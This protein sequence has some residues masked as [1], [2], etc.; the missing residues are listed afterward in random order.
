LN[1]IPFFSVL[2]PTK[3]RSHIVG[4]AIQSILNQS[5]RDFEIILVDNDDSDATERSVNGFSDTRLKYFRTGSLNMCDNWEFA[6]EQA[7]GKFVTVLE[8]KQAYYPHALDKIHQAIMEKSAEVV[9]WGWDAYY[10]NLKMAC[11]VSQKKGM[12]MFT[13]DCI[14]NLYVTRPHA[15]WELL[16][17]VLNS[18][19]SHDL[20]KKIKAL[21]A[22]GK[23]FSEMS[24]D[25]CAAFYTLAH[26]EQ[27][28]LIRER[29]GLGGYFHLSN[30]KKI[31]DDPENKFSY[32]GK[33]ISSDLLTDYVPI[34]EHRLLHNSVYNDFLRIRENLKGRLEAHKMLPE[35]YANLCLSDLA[36]IPFGN[37]NIKILK[38]ISKYM[39]DNHISKSSSC[40]YYLKPLS[41]RKLGEITWL[42]RL[43]NRLIFRTWN[44]KNILE[45]SINSKK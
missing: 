37:G 31:I 19:I 23:F 34:K 18:C 45:A 39:K 29:L 1:K 12:E 22:V 33:G 24:P 21:P 7:R 43:R 41:K 15:S 28:C 17:R 11:E 2:L 8:D 9:V 42:K 44:A 32:F 26:A 25:L 14:L 6:L 10:D 40:L 3:N 13:S 38:E 36:L 35:V 30:A 27:L 16:P 20:I 5:F 4:Y